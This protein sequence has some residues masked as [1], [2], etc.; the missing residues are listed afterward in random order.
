MG[1]NIKILFFVVSLFIAQINIFGQDMKVIE[2][3][4]F[5]ISPGKDLKVDASSGSVHIS[6]WDKNEVY[7]KILGDDKT[8]DKMEF[9]FDND[10]NRVEVIA[11]RKSWFSGWFSHGLKLHFEITVPEKFNVKVETGGGS[12]HTEDISGE[13]NLSTS[14][15][16]IKLENVKGEFDVSTSGGSIT[17]FNFQGD[18]DASTSGGSINLKGS[19]SKIKAET[20]GGGISLDYDGV[21]KGIYLST[22]GGGIQ[23]NLPED[24]NASAEL[25]TS[26]GGISCDL[27]ANNAKRISRT[28]FKADL[29][30]GGKSLY[31]ETSGGSINVRKK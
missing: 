17:A 25:Y 14:G 27:T 4:T 12:V 11:K 5:Q 30:K 28:E 29:N 26:G 3:K 31:A 9:K 18:L 23:I 15:G 7:I 21:N 10:E 19:D 8:K 2:E 20:S 24:F 16:S 13:I 6:S 22:S 1:K